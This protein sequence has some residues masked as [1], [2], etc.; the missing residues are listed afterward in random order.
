MAERMQVE[1]DDDDALLG[2]LQQEGVVGPQTVEAAREASKVYELLL[3]SGVSRGDA[4]A[5]VSE[6]FS[7]PR[8]TA[9]LGRLPFMSLVGGSCFDLRR[10]ANGVAWDF[11]R[12]EDR[13]R[14]REQ[15]R[16]EKPFLVVGSPPCTEFSAVQNLNRRHFSAAEARRRRAE[17]MTLLGFALE[18]YQLQLDAGRHFLHEHPASASSWREAK[19]Q[20]L[21]QDT[22]VTEVVGHQCR[23]GLRTRGPGGT[24]MPALKPT[25][26]LSSSE[27]ILRQLGLR[28]RGA[29]RHQPLL[30]SGRASAAAIYPPGLCKAILVGRRRNCSGTAGR[31]RSQCSR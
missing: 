7:P 12:A 29:H 19:V 26:F 11:R 25:R 28:C 5:K 9:E 20:R 24:W 3:V 21:R 31:S 6:L 1:V 30:G 4:V 22:R 14:A 16:R 13:E 10:D 15:I 17:A 27:D 8:V 18:V 2:A 23:Y